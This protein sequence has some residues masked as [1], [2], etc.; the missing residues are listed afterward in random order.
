MFL[1]FIVSF[2]ISF[3]FLLNNI[4]SPRYRILVFKSKTIKLG[5]LNVDEITILEWKPLFSLKTFYF[6]KGDAQEIYHTHSFE[7]ISILLHGNYME[8]FVNPE[9]NNYWSESRNRSR[10]IYIPKDRYHQITQSQGCRTIMLTGPWSDFYKEYNPI[11]NEII[12]STHGRKE[13]L[14]RKK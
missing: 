11:T 2:F 7:A 6:H 8:A 4:S 3:I 10:I 13:V 1:L 9:T 12:V 14:R 5:T